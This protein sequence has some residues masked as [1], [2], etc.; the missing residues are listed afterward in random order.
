MQARAQLVL[1]ETLTEQA[2]KLAT[3]QAAVCGMSDE[4]LAASTEV[5]S[6]AETEPVGT[7]ASLAGVPKLGTG[8]HNTRANGVARLHGA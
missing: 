7:A 5:Y 1:S 8:V 4:E 6:S 3:A 2:N